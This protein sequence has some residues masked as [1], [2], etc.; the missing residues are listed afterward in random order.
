MVKGNS[1]SKALRKRILI[2]DDH[3]VVRR[4]L[5]EFLSQQPDLCVCDA[6]ADAEQALDVVDREPVDLA[7]VDICLGG[8]DG[9]TLTCRLKRKHPDLVVLILSMHDE[10]IY[11]QRARQA[12]ASGFVTKLGAGETLL[13]AIHQVLSGQTYFHPGC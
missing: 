2:V 10:S 5:V 1:G 13:D 7:I 3:Y 8:M 4:G 6:V 12:G 11:G 9:L